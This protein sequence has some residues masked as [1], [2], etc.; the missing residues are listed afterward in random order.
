MLKIASLVEFCVPVHLA[1]SELMPHFNEGLFENSCSVRPPKRKWPFSIP[2]HPRPSGSGADNTWLL[3]LDFDIKLSLHQG[4]PELTSKQIYFVK[5]QYIPSPAYFELT[6]GMNLQAWHL[7]AGC[8]EMNYM[9]LRRPM[10]MFQKFIF[11]ISLG[12]KSKYS[13]AN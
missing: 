5:V 8:C 1:R 4:Y 13:Y 6:R 2:Q 7:H 10:P 3:H 9:F 12:S 11:L